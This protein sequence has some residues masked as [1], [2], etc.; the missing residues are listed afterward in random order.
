MV[1]VEAAGFRKTEATF[2]L[3]TSETKG[4]NLKLPLAS[5]KETITVEVTPPSVTRMIAA[6]RRRFLRTQ[7]EICPRR[8]EIYGMFWQWLR[9]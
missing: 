3:N 2:T 8:I 7:F 6:C 5:A 4:I 9:A 1:S